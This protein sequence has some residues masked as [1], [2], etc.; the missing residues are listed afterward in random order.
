[1][2]AEK[3]DEGDSPDDGAHVASPSGEQVQLNALAAT[4]VLTLHLQQLLLLLL[5]LVLP[6]SAVIGRRVMQPAFARASQ[7]DLLP[8]QQEV[9]AAPERLEEG[10]AVGRTASA[11]GFRR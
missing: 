3:A 11:R 7:V 6:L 4:A 5:L 10:P 1:M 9:A 2:E 8:V